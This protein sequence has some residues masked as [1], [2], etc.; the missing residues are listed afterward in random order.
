[1]TAARVNEALTTILSTCKS[2]HALTDPCGIPDVAT[3]GRF[4]EAI[5]FPFQDGW[6]AMQEKAED[7]KDIGMFAYR[8]HFAA[9]VASDVRPIAHLIGIPSRRFK[10]FRSDAA[11]AELAKHKAALISQWDIIRTAT[12]WSRLLPQS[13]THKAKL[14]ELL[15]EEITPPK[16]TKRPVAKDVVKR[17]KNS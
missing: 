17:H 9:T 11:Q 1:M 12:D 13:S 10:K 16:K 2:M 3:I 6:E 14:R 5:V 15:D 4:E 8:T 7:Q